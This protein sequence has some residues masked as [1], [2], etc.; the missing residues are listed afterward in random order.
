VAGVRLLEALH[1][2]VNKRPFWTEP[3]GS[4]QWRKDHAYV[5]TGAARPKGISTGA[6]ASDYLFLENYIR[7]RKPQ[8]IL[9]LGGG[10]TTSVMAEAMNGGLIVSVDHVLQYLQNTGS[11]LTPKRRAVVDLHLSPGIVGEEYAGISAL[12]YYSF[13]PGNY[14]MIFVD[15]PPVI[16]GRE[17]FPSIDAILALGD[18]PTDIIIDG[19]LPTVNYF[20]RW[21]WRPVYYDPCLKLG[22]LR[23]VCESDVLAKPNSYRRPRVV[24]AS[25]LDLLQ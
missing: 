13:P 4:D 8:K 1:R 7:A 14:D 2:R 17:Q 15:G 20:S 23:G 3:P 9:E 5:M 22:F 6:E 19:R 25:A 21:F 18:G 11:L 24:L 12:H 10:A 16:Y